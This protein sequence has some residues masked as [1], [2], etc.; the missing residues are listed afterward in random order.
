[1][2]HS[3]QFIIVI[4]NEIVSYMLTFLGTYK[5]PVNELFL[6]QLNT[7][8]KNAKKSSVFVCACVLSLVLLFDTNKLTDSIKHKTFYI[9]R[10]KLSKAIKMIKIEIPNHAICTLIN[11]R[12]G[13]LLGNR[14]HHT[15]QNIISFIQNLK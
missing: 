1:M 4:Q 13:S 5:S 11:I 7:L 15:K 10:R 14:K 3:R 8:S 12:Q 6:S 2:C 9:K